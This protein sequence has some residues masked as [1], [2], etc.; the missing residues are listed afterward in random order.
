MRKIMLLLVFLLFAGAQMLQAQRTITGT[1]LDATDN[2]G[3]PSVQIVVK[4]MTSVGTATDVMGRYS[5]TVPNDA[6]HLVF[7][8]M[9][10][11]TQE[12]EISGRTTVDVVMRPDAT[13][14]EEVVVTA[15]G[16]SRS[17][18][19]LAYS[20]T[21]VDGSQLIQSGD[22]SA[23]N[24]LQGKIPGLSLT[25]NS[26]APGSSTRVLLRG[27]SSVTGNNEPLFVVNG[28]PVS[29]AATQVTGLNNTVDFGNAMND[30][31]P[32]DV[33]SVTVL[34]GAAAAALYGSRAANGVIL[35]T[36]KSGQARE[37]VKVDYAGTVTFTNYV[38]ILQFQNEFGAGLFG[39]YMYEEQMSYGPRM[40]GV[41]RLIGHPVDNMQLYKPYVGM[42]NNVEDF[43][44]TGIMFNNSF[45][46]SG[47]NEKTTFFASYSNVKDDGIVPTNVDSYTRNSIMLNAKTK[48]RRMTVSGNLNY[49]Q[50][51]VSAIGGGQGRTIFNDIMQTPRDF[52]LVDMD[53]KNNGNKFWDFDNFYTPFSG[54]PWVTIHENRSL[55][56]ENNVFGNVTVSAPVKEWITLNVRLGNNF[57]TGRMRDWRAV[58]AYSPN[59]HW[60]GAYSSVEEAGYYRVYNVFRNEF[61]GDAFATFNA[62]VSDFSIIGTLGVNINHRYSTTQQASVDKLT[63]PGFYNLSNSPDRP[64]SSSSWSQRRLV[65]AFM[66]ADVGYKRQVFLNL[67]AR[68]DWSST[69]PK[70]NNNFF[71]PSVGV[72]W[73]FT[74][75]FPELQNYITFGK[76]RGSYGEVGNDPTA[77]ILSADMVSA[78]TIGGTFGGGLAFPLL[79]V[80]G[81][82]V[83]NT[84]G[85]QALKPE[86]TK[87]WEGGADIRLLNNRVGFD[88]AFYKRNSV[89]QIMTVPI[90]I[91]TGYSTAYMNIGNVENKGIELSVNGTPVQTKDF[92][93]DLTWTFTKNNNKVLELT[94]GTERHDLYGLTG[95]LAIVAEVGKPMATFMGYGPQMTADGKPI[96]GSNG[97]VLR[98]S[99]DRIHMGKSDHDYVMGLNSSIK[100]KGFYLVAQFDFRKGGLFYS[101]TAS[102]NDW[103]GNSVRTLY[104]NRDPYVVPNSVRQN[105]A[106]TSTSPSSVPQYIENTIPIS[107][108]NFYS[109]FDAMNQFGGDAANLIDK[110]SFRA[111]EIALGYRVNS[112]FLAKTPFS[113]LDF[114]V[115]A[116]N[117][118]VWVPSTNSWID[119][120]V[121]TFGNGVEAQYGEFSGYPST[122]SWGFSLKASF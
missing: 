80:A 83:S 95:G 114:S 66:S 63:L 57:L 28:V 43:Y 54:N 72:S 39:H 69:L 16:I 89:N 14:L 68:N 5:L 18:K 56:G 96:V 21:Q 86:L 108:A 119:P 113:N 6:T 47:G 73:L 87:E 9:G 8:F 106:W 110:T 98:N 61:N 25:S 32:N 101:R 94:E 4:G 31:N 13:A 30:I 67:A 49:I 78:G 107:Y 88:V 17:E 41:N 64:L 112:K 109:V 111:R 3:I 121:T 91:S 23:L 36:T 81:Y 122:R 51:E 65:G 19:G 82:R 52:S 70:D 62:E 26:G 29:N 46:F 27:F 115:V 34:K 22:R 99:A 74:E 45:S 118:F 7:S 85:N 59:S 20:I 1:V 117:L 71:Y 58:N 79:G 12:I 100:Y 53:Y 55:Y 116:R 60:Y 50:K 10:M 42:P 75:T 92:S 105:P 40:D 38:P 120:D 11:T 104:N 35:I 76:L 33:E 90:P 2:Q 103:A 77:Y 37:R 84:I 97:V 24:A 44:E 93:W 15:L 48:G 102:I